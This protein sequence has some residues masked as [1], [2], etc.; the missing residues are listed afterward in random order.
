MA[1][2][3]EEV[4]VYSMKKNIITSLHHNIQSSIPSSQ[5]RFGPRG[6]MSCCKW[7][8][9]SLSG[10]STYKGDNCLLSYSRGATH[11]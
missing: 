4:A 2:R 10:T 7:Q 11:N 1:T 3:E 5:H 6:K 9:D 8:Q